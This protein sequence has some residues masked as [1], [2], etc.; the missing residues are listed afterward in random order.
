MNDSNE[1]HNQSRRRQLQ[2]A[3]I[4]VAMVLFLGAI[5]SF[6]L[7]LASLF[8]DGWQIS[9]EE[10]TVAAPAQEA[11]EEE[12]QPLVAFPYFAAEIVLNDTEC[13]LR[14]V[15]SETVDTA[16]VLMPFLH[17][18][19][20]AVVDSG[21]IHHAGELSFWPAN[22]EVVKRSD[23]SVLTGFGRLAEETK[24][25]GSRVQQQPL[26]V[27]LDGE[28]I[29]GYDD[30]W[31][32]GL[33]PDGSSFYLVEPQADNRSQLVIRNL[34]EGSEHR[35]D[36]GEILDLPGGDVLSRPIYYSMDS[37]EVMIA[38]NIEG[39]GQHEF[40]PAKTGESERRRVTALKE[41]RVLSARFASSTDGYFL[42]D[43]SDEGSLA[44]SRQQIQWGDDQ[45]MV[46]DWLHS[47]S[48]FYHR[49]QELELSPDGTFLL[50]NGRELA[51]LYTS[52]GRRAFR[53]PS[54][55][56]E[57]DLLGE[58]RTEVAE[59]QAAQTTRGWFVGNQLLVG[60]HQSLREIEEAAYDVYD[61]EG[62]QL[63]AEPIGRI[64]KTSSSE[65]AAGDH[66]SQGLQARDGRLTF[67][68]TRG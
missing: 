22:F 52:S 12:K 41:N 65:C 61:L 43:W 24:L 60:Q 20:F 32:F 36:L 14:T 38:P 68:T 15:R 50:L 45:R 55:E 47:L 23:G 48:P 51:L 57:Q 53:V 8:E 58:L 1:Q 21:G 29:Y 46:T 34:E 31:A 44:I 2:I 25:E 30:I 13:R 63:G 6:L 7:S 62:I 66:P 16:V 39:V 49:A 3:L 5:A 54:G 37:S 42:Y 26:R 67:L 4:V 18:G 17:G 33:A 10:E 40:F 9:N 19:R 59:E 27:F 56:F 28:L 64:F 35:F 11:L